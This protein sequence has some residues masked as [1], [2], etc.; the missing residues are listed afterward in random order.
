MRK[1]RLTEHAKEEIIRRQI[2]INILEQTISN[3]QA[4][5][6]AVNNRKCYQATYIFENQKKY[7]VRIIT[8]EKERQLMIITV[9]KQ[10][11]LENILRGN[12]ESHI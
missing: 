3:P 10:V 2:P 1:Y 8:E 5:V 4:I 7:L 9:I 6:S 12:Y 11:K